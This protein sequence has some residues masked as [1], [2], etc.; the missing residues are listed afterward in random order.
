M[1]INTIKWRLIGKNRD[2]ENGRDEQ[3][4]NSKKIRKHT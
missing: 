2:T 3:E 4:E 1:H